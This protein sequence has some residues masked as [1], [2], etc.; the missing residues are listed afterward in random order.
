MRSS[1]GALELREMCFCTLQDAH[2]PWMYYR[3]ERGQRRFRLKSQDSLKKCLFFFSQQRCA[4]VIPSSFYVKMFQN[5]A[6][7]VTHETQQCL[8]HS[9][10]GRNINELRKYKSLLMTSDFHTT[11]SCVYVPVEGEVMESDHWRLE[12]WWHMIILGFPCLCD[13]IITSGYMGVW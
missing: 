9:Y 12:K 7:N 6:N 5:T 11:A 10:S 1:H 13:L 8:S 2:S 4:D 3:Q